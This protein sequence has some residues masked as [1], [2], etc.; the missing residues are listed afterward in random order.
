MTPPV[1]VV[2]RTKDEAE[3]IGRNLEIV[4]AQTLEAELIVV[5]SGSA[6][7]TTDIV[8]AAGVE[9]VEIP[10]S[11]FTYGYSLN[12]GAERASAP[13]I[14][15][16]SAHAFPC[17]EGWLERMVAA[18]DDPRVACA[19]AGEGDA[20][21]NPLT[22]PA[23]QDLD[24]VRRHPLW[25]Y[26]NAAGGFRAELWRQRRFRED[27]PGVEDKEWAW[28]WIQRG[29][30]TVVDPALVVDHDHSDETLRERYDRARREWVG[31]SMFVEVP[32]YGVRELAHEWWTEQS[33]RSSRLRARLS[34]S[35]AAELAGTYA[36]RRAGLRAAR[37]AERD[38]DR[39]VPIGPV[40]QRMPTLRG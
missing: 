35:R 33:G 4:Q 6:D 34:P 40:G 13:V 26:S 38:A 10:A 22:G 16:L 24:H 7:G 1:S 29:Y 39:L 19:C 18:F 5:D 11:A 3:S 15:A 36:G 21:G 12:V 30:V 27:M 31:L 28:H 17:D 25:G 37:G 2:I 8:R 23:V 14:V 20:E 9:L 32:R